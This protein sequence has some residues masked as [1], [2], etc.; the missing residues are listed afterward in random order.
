[1]F[2]P[3]SSGCL[4]DKCRKFSFEALWLCSDCQAIKDGR[5]RLFEIIGGEEE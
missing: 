3:Q 2:T 5:Q 4:N 1:M